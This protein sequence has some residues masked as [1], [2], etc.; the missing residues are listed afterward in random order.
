MAAD[1]KVGIEA[2][3]LWKRVGRSS[4][5]PGSFSSIA[6]FH[7]LSF[8]HKKSLTVSFFHWLRFHWLTGQAERISPVKAV[9]SKLK[10]LLEDLAH[11]QEFNLDCDATKTWVNK[12][13]AVC[14]D[15]SH[16]DPHNLSQKVH[17]HAKL[18]EEL[19]SYKPHIDLLPK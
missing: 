7:F 9:S 19:A 6:P 2:T 11:L 10:G 5:C 18:E 13:L 1:E 15:D 3:A 14:T 16:L 4:K 17:N 12:T 8:G